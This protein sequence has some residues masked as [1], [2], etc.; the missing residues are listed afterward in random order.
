MDVLARAVGLHRIGR[1]V[2]AHRP[3]DL[4]HAVKVGVGEHRMPVLRNENRVRMQNGNAVS[5]GSGV[6]VWAR[7]PL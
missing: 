6:L 2:G 1:D 3:H 4:L 5:A 7:A